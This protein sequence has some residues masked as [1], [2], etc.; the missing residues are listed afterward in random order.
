[1]RDWFLCVVRL[2]ISLDHCFAPSTIT[3]V[4]TG[5]ALFITFTPKRTSTMTEGLEQK[6]SETAVAETA[7]L[8]HTT[9]TRPMVKVVKQALDSWGLKY[10]DIPEAQ[11]Q[12]N[13]PMITFGMNGDTSNYRVLLSMDLDD[14]IFAVY[15]T[16][17]TKV[18]EIHRT[19]IAE[20]FMRINYNVMLG[21]FDL[22][23]KD[24]EIRFK[25]SAIVKESKLSVEMVRQMVGVAMNTMDKFFPGIM[26]IQYA[27]KTPEEAL[28]DINNPPPQPTD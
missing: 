24:G 10:G 21:H 1:M 25:V 14:E 22:D 7:P 23:A 18:D 8:P 28:H 6:E 13:I 17:P 15:Y 5:V 16:S 26:A 4:V 9:E 3:L 2:G 27:N 12:P 19:A 11:C 20:Y